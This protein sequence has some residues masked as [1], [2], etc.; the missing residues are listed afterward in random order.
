M[1]T[2]NEDYFERGIAC[3]IS[4]Y[5]NYRWI[6]E[7]TI[8]LAMTLIDHLDIKRT[9]KV[10]DIGCAKGYLVKAFRM[11]YRQAWGIDKSNYAIDKVDPEVID[12]CFRCA[13]GHI[14][15]LPDTFQLAIAKDVFEHL[16]IEELLVVLH[17]I[18]TDRLFVVVPLGEDGKYR[19]PAY[20]LDKTH[21]IREDEVWWMS[22]F[23][24]ND[25][26]VTNFTYRV[27]GIKDNWAF[28][29]NGNG[30]FLLKRVIA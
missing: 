11:L 19:V 21:L 15:Y 14:S 23:E 22:F 7:L 10:L 2:Y 17:N 1:I 24:D 25:W 18:H 9:D 3:G 29:S 30:F 26:K 28:Y 8:P 16:T 20:E 4:L 5:D 13:I 27:P 6:P 12:F